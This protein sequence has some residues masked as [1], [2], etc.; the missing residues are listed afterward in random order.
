M[1]T[2]D[3][4]TEIYCII[5]EFSKKYPAVTVVTAFSDVTDTVFFHLRV[6]K[7]AEIVCH[8]K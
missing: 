3:K 6:K 1:V 4:I 5:D 7:L 8:T 2:K